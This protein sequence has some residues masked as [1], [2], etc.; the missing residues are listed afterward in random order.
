[1]DENTTVMITPEDPMD[2]QSVPAEEA[3][4][5]YLAPEAVQAPQFLPE[6]APAAPVAP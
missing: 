6:E 1:M 4:P 5:E 3:T 2:A